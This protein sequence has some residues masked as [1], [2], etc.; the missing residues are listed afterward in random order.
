MR[1]NSSSELLDLVGGEG[2]YIYSDHSRK[3]MRSASIPALFIETMEFLYK[4]GSWKACAM[5]S[6]PGVENMVGIICRSAQKD[7]IGSKKLDL[8]KEIE[9]VLIW[10]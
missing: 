7:T 5:G 10:E 2:Q 6:H 1:F 9:G 4:D 8:I 3:S